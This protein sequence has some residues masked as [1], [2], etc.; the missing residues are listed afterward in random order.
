MN[1]LNAFYLRVR[2]KDVIIWEK[3]VFAK[4]SVDKCWIRKMVLCRRLNCSCQCLYPHRHFENSCLWRHR[5]GRRSRR[6]PRQRTLRG[7]NSLPTNFVAGQ[8]LHRAVKLL[9]VPVTLFYVVLILPHLPVSLLHVPVRLPQPAVTQNTS[10]SNLTASRS[11]LT[12][13]CGNFTATSGNL[14]ARCSNSTRPP[15]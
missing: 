1:N 9:Q 15:M 6:F 11:N 3:F 10:C 5:H 12:I 2:D 4:F 8:L 14:T 7:R 13:T